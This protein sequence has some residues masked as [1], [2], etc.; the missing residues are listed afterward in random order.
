MLQSLHAAFERAKSDRA[1]VLL[2]GRDDVFSAGFDLKVMKKGGPNALS[3]LRL[4]YSL[5]AKVL[6]HPQPVVVAC[7]GHA[8]AMGVFLMLAADYVVGTRGDFKVAANEVAIGL[9]MP[10]VA[11]AMLE[12]RL[13][14][15]T[16]QRA[17]TLAEYFDVESALAAGFF[18]ELVT[19]D[20][21][22]AR[23]L[24]LITSFAELPQV[25]HDV[26]KKRI[27]KRTRRRLGRDIWFDLFDAAM[28][29]LRGTKPR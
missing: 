15:A 14:P 23:A 8:M 7:N 3:M 25:P 16:Y 2:T 19:V 6:G 10:R 12:H 11:A 24:E 21:L 20:R 9:P 18:D 5:P 1:A 13:T 28:L 4:G 27:R 17:V 22:E 29:G 26:S